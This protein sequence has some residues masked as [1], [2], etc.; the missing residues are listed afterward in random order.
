MSDRCGMLRSGRRRTPEGAQVVF[1][2]SVVVTMP[3]RNTADGPSWRTS[4]TGEGIL[5]LLGSTTTPP[6]RI[7]L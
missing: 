4:T 2:A 6:L 3:G 5:V 1:E 7:W